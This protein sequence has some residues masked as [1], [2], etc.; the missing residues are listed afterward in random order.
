MTFAF[1]TAVDV[2]G[3][4]E[5]RLPPMPASAEDSGISR[6]LLSRSR[7]LNMDPGATTPSVPAVAPR[8]MPVQTMILTISEFDLEDSTARWT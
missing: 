7:S 1:A 3:R 2:D 6:V 8:C 5:R 4:A